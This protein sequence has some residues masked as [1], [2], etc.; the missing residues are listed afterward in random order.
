VVLSA[1]G[2]SAVRGA[3]PVPPGAVPGVPAAWSFPVDRGRCER[4]SATIEFALLLPVVVLCMVLLL[5]TGL[6]AAELLLAQ[7]AAREAARVAAVDDDRAALRVAREVAGARPVEVRT[8]PVAG[9][10]RAG[11]LVTVEVSLRSL[12]FDRLGVTVWLPGRAVMRVEA[13]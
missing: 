4:G 5:Q 11:D 2:G 13:P 7:S 1:I 3:P 6:A 8:S 10:R 9:A 12:A